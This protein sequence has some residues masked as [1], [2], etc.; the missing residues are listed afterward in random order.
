ME[1]ELLHTDR[2]ILKKYTPDHLKF[3]FQHFSMNQIIQELGFTTKKEYWAEKER[4]DGGYSSYNRSM[5]QFKLILKNT[6]G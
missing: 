4:L 5:I 3:I 1:F 6:R 2:L